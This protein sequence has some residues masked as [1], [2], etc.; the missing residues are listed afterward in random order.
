MLTYIL[1]LAIYKGGVAGV[2]FS[3]RAACETALRAVQ[4][5]SILKIGACVPKASQP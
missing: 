3:D 5:Q 2:E 1:I 4:Q